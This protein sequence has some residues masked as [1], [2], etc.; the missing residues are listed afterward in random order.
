MKHNCMLSV[1]LKYN[2]GYTQKEAYILLLSIR[3]L[4]FFEFLNAN[5]V[6]RTTAFKGSSATCT[7]KLVFLLILISNPLNNAPPPVK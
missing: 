3:K 4:Y 6:P 7:S 2:F 5:P 1:K